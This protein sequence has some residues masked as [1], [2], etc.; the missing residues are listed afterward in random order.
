[1]SHPKILG[2]VVL[3][4]RQA[5]NLAEGVK[6]FIPGD[7]IRQ[8]I[9]RPCTPGDFIWVQEPYYHCLPRN[10]WSCQTINTILPGPRIGMKFPEW[11]RKLPHRA[12]YKNGSQM[13]KS[14]SR[15]TLVVEALGTDQDGVWCVIRM[16]QI[17]MLVAALVQEAK[18]W[19]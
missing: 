2:R 9:K 12:V 13:P 4:E 18:P 3:T 5:R 15:S 6:L 10:R 11:I 1:M 16:Q 17:D 7:Q 8:H 19:G 14:E